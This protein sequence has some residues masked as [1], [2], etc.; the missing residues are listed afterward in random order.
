MIG[1]GPGRDAGPESAARDALIAMQRTLDYA[2]VLR[3]RLAEPDAGTE[4]G[5]LDGDRA[6][7]ASVLAQLDREVMHAAQ[8]QDAADLQ[9]AAELAHVSAAA[10]AQLAQ[11]I[12]A[13][14][15][16]AMAE[17]Y[18]EALAASLPP[19]EAQPP[20]A[21]R[22]HADR[23]AAV[24][25]RLDRAQSRRLLARI[26]E[27]NRAVLA[28]PR[29][30]SV[31][32]PLMRRWLRLG[33]HRE[34]LQ[35]YLANPKRMAELEHHHAAKAA[36]PATTEA[37]AAAPA[38]PSSSVAGAT[39]P[40]EKAARRTSPGTPELVPEAV[41]EGTSKGRSPSVTAR[42]YANLWSREIMA[43]VLRSF[44]AQGLPP[45]HRRLGW[46][47]D[48]GVIIDQLQ[49]VLDLE[50]ERFGREGEEQLRQIFYPSDVLAL[51]DSY[52]PVAP[53]PSEAPRLHHLDDGPVG[54]AT[55][56]PA[57]GGVL[58]AEAQALLGA[59]LRRMGSRYVAAADLLAARGMTDEQI[60]LKLTPELV[61][62]TPIDLL[63]ARLISSNGAITYRAPTA[64]DRATEE[65][66]A[67]KGADG[68]RWSGPRPGGLRSVRAL[69]QG[70]RDPALWNWVRV[71]APAD[72]TA[73]E[74]AA[75]LFDDRDGT[76]RSYLAPF[77]TAA[78]PYFA[79]PPEWAARIP[80]ARLHRPKRGSPS[81]A[82]AAEDALVWSRV[83][84]DAALTQGDAAARTASAASP[85]ARPPAP[86]RAD[87]RDQLDRSGRQLDYLVGALA[88]WR[89]TAALVP[90]QL[91]VE[92]ARVHILEDSPQELQRWAHAV[93]AQAQLLEELCGDVVRLAELPSVHG[94]DGAA[95]TGPLAELFAEYARAAG[96]SALADTG[97]RALDRARFRA[98]SLA[99]RSAERMVHISGLA[100]AS[101]ESIQDETKRVSAFA[102][103]TRLVQ[104]DLWKGAAE[105]RLA[106]AQGKLEPEDVA[107][108]MLAAEENQLRAQSAGS[109]LQLDQLARFAEANG[110]LPDADDARYTSR[111][112]ASL[113]ERMRD[114]HQAQFPGVGGAELA[115]KKRESMQRSVAFARAELAT[116]Q[117]DARIEAFIKRVLGDIRH[118]QK[119]EQYLKIALMIGIGVASGA[120]AGALGAFAQGALLGEAATGA[121][122][123]MQVVRTARLLGA[124][125]DI[126]ADAA[127][128]TAAGAALGS[129]DVG[130]S[131]AEN[132]LSNGATAAALRPFAQVLGSLRGADH[133]A[134]SL[135]QKAAGTGQL[136][137]AKGAVLTLEMVTGAAVG[138]AARRIVVGQEP[139]AA[140][141]QEWMLQGASMAVGRAVGALSA[142]MTA[143][144]HELA[145]AA[146]AHLTRSRALA[147]RAR[148]A[149]HDAAALERSGDPEQALAVLGLYR[150][151][152]EEEEL[153]LRDVLGGRG[154]SAQDRV[155]LERH[156]AGVAADQ[157]QVAGRAFEVLP[158][159]LAGLEETVPG[160]TWW[161]GTPEQI[162]R[163]LDQARAAGL[164]VE[165]LGRE[166]RTWKVRYGEEELIID[167]LPHTGRAAAPGPARSAE[168]AAHNQRTADAA[169][170]MQALWE[171]H[172]AAQIEAEA[173]RH[174]G[175]VERGRLTI[176]AQFA[177]LETENTHH[178]T[179]ED[180]LF[181]YAGDGAMNRRY[182]DQVSTDLGQPAKIHDGSVVRS[183]AQTSDPTGYLTS[184]NYDRALH[185]ARF[186][187]QTPALRGRVVAYELRPPQVPAGWTHPH[188][189]ARAKVRTERGEVWIYASELNLAI[190]GGATRFD[191]AVAATTPEDFRAL[192]AD[193]RLLGGDDPRVIAQLKTTSKRTLVWGGSATGAWAAEDAAKH[194]VA[195][196]DLIGGAS[197]AGRKSF[198]AQHR[199]LREQRA[200]AETADDAAAMRELDG[201]LMTLENRY[202]FTGRN[203]D[204]NRLP[205]GSAFNNEKIHVSVAYPRKLHPTKEG[206]VEV[207]FEDGRVE[208]YEQVVLA[209]GQDVLADP[210]LA[211]LL[212]AGAS[213]AAGDG[214]SAADAA[215]VPEGGLA[216]R[217]V[218]DRNGSL[219]YLED[220]AG[221]GLRLSG[222]AGFSPQLAPWVVAGER[223]RFLE[224]LKRVASPSEP[225]GQFPP[226][227][228]ASTGV[229]T[230]GEA[231]GPR[232]QVAGEVHAARQFRFVELPGH[233]ALRLAAGQE[234]QWPAA[235][236]AYFT[237]ALHA[238]P[239]RVAVTP[240][241]SGAAGH[242]YDVAIGLEHVGRLRI[243]PG[244]D[245]AHAE[246]QML[247]VL[248]NARLRSLRMMNERGAIAAG[249]DTGAM[250]AGN[251]GPQAKTIEQ[252]AKELPTEPAA[253]ETALEPLSRAVKQTA[254]GLAGLHAAY[255]G[256]DGARMTSAA[257]AGEI[258]RLLE[259][260]ASAPVRA[261]LGEDHAEVMR[262]LRK[263]VFPKFEAAELVATAYHGGAE[264][265]SFFVGGGYDKDK[266][267]AD[268]ATYNVSE[269]RNSFK[270]GEG[271]ATG[272]ADLARFTDSLESLPG[273]AKGEIREL[274]RAFFDAYRKAHEDASS[275]TNDEA[276]ALLFYETRAQLD[277][278]R[279][280]DRR[281][282]MRLRRALGLD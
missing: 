71:E 265:E 77:L 157:R 263:T 24:F 37:A 47:C 51:I 182:D 20:P 15:A 81:A 210:A 221:Q 149:G 181:V 90:A 97:R 72:A 104:S 213:R 10:R 117:K 239:G 56:Q 205:P 57:L 136:A 273:M 19:D 22:E 187:L 254:N 43:A 196:V 126:T 118:K 105:L 125:I 225:D 141:V 5:G 36:V 98:T 256:K 26:G 45:L 59:S 84:D 35:S 233:G 54:P 32:D 259:V 91:F 101:Q 277:R 52:R 241:I 246:Q 25:A 229:G 2:A 262:A 49:I 48:T 167:E 230:G 261:A 270:D 60:H 87:L 177:G 128:N 66:A 134:A 184:R 160:G 185:L 190:G 204:R 7:L 153:L 17:P 156:R 218:Y 146:G 145:H 228:R 86:D 171:Q 108:L 188:R 137:L 116:L 120:V 219:V 206:R 250:L 121:V 200:R 240:V 83:V 88:P 114:N 201:R 223:T 148:R 131:F 110:L 178:A 252:M 106:Q 34:K 63:V 173:G 280:G 243:T 138:Y 258:Q 174:G 260:L 203:L 28:D 64:R 281:A 135:W 132:L 41:A 67:T 123:V 269:S 248:G 271:I 33:T 142:S 46:A 227:S 78:P 179:G 162:V 40:D 18:E 89:A 139:S 39:S 192:R 115:A 234:A 38:S 92:R 158:L 267:F 166:G 165:V 80:E 236:T 257:K 93:A 245:E 65:R 113:A 3:R 244:M 194:G 69:W 130:A 220:A 119:R 6:A 68:D 216:L 29:H 275:T 58:A 13:T 231:Q 70:D 195:R 242:I 152:L 183:S 249:A 251:A 12:A 143:R 193:G 247:A 96:A 124:A 27:A 75:T 155:L 99:V 100:V 186:S 209:H 8:Q 79:I 266:G 279:S 147:E 74:V 109:A 199:A 95:P 180:A 163:G 9:T 276:A 238:E 31:T 14:G 278:I 224:A 85:G 1:K 164:E 103:D 168:E 107:E 176:G 23:V 237:Q 215:P 140:T 53:Q 274:K 61:T 111:A 4:P 62:S 191:A 169:A 127:L 189:S 94:A 55:W 133:A 208:V 198:D 217:P 154:L 151:S 76:P 159:R 211:A 42:E 272:I 282:L 207:T 73:E 264:V 102:S 112:L 161:R 129:G 170:R 122:E 214:D 82:P 255:R 235:I 44:A 222:A 253:R 144:L 268:L 16:A 172:T 175:A 21:L 202:A 226:V 197:P 232:L 150:R 11:P 212:G 50:R 30:V